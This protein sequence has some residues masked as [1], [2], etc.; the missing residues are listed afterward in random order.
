[1]QGT[2]RPQTANC[3]T[4]LCEAMGVQGGALAAGSGLWAHFLT[5]D[6]SWQGAG[7]RLTQLHAALHLLM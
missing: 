6:A 5:R 4:G 3:R 1:M 7:A 2:A